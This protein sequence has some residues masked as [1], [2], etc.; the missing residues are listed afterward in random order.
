MNIV[1]QPTVQTLIKNHTGKFLKNSKMFYSMHGP[2]PHCME[3][4]E[5]FKDAVRV[6]QSNGNYHSLNIDADRMSPEQL[7]DV[8][9]F[10]SFANGAMYGFPTFS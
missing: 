8:E 4:T 3:L 9:K 1:L 7:Q 6:M 5:A 2:N 10:A